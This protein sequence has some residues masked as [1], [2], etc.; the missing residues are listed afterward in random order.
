MTIGVDNE[1]ERAVEILKGLKQLR[2]L[3]GPYKPEKLLKV[4]R[5][6]ELIAY[7]DLLRAADRLQDVIWMHSP[8][9]KHV[10]A[11]CAMLAFTPYHVGSMDARLKAVATE[12]FADQATIRRWGDIGLKKIAHKL[13]LR[14]DDIWRPPLAVLTAELQEA[15]LEVSI[16]YY[17]PAG[18]PPPQRPIAIIDNQYCA[19]R[20]PW[21]PGNDEDK[22]T[23]T[24]LGDLNF[25][26][27]SARF[28]FTSEELPKEVQFVFRR[29]T[30]LRYASYVRSD[31]ANVYI[32][33]YH[34]K[35]SVA[36]EIGPA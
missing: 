5:L 19:W 22:V 13:S 31:L 7:G 34:V 35:E 21:D 17:Y 26:L 23:E 12:D 15:A 18:L 20:F 32:Q 11:A 10:K 8:H 14:H 4:P 3:E 33:T 1:H 29:K 30:D 2:R 25:K 28:E 24:P 27:A 9:D 36:L 6:I 16:H